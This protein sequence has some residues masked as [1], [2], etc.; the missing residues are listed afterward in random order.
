LNKDKH[1]KGKRD[2]EVVRLE[3]LAPRQDPKAGKGGVLFGQGSE[4]RRPEGT[5]KP[6]R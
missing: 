5:R 4:T 3:D 2:D 6:T 1:R